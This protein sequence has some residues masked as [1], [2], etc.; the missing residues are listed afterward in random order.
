MNTVTK[1]TILDAYERLAPVVTR[2]P[3]TR[4]AGL[5]KRFDADIYLKREDLQEVR[6][7]KIRGSYNR[8]ALLSDLERARGIVCASAGNHAQGVAKSCA[9]LSIRGKVYMP[10]N[11]PRQKVDRVRAFGKDVVEVVLVGDSFDESFAAA[12]V[13]TEETGAVLVHPFDDPAVVSGQGT[14]AVEVFE[15]L[16]DVD[17]FVIP[18]GGGGLIAGMGTYAK[19]MRSKVQVIGVEPTGAASMY[20]A[21]THGTVVTL[22]AVDTFVDGVAVKTVGKN[23]FALAEKCVDHYELVPEGAVCTVMVALYQENGIVTEPAGALSVAALD[24]MREQLVGKKVVCVISGGNNDISRYAEVL[25]RS[26]V[27]RGLKHY[28]VVSFP[29]RPGALRGFLND[30][31]GPTDDITLFEYVKKNNRETG[32]ALVGIE[33]AQ[34][35]DLAALVDRMD[36]KGI[37]YEKLL[38]DSP[39]YR[40][41]V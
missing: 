19:S 25:E 17:L 28:F 37:V 34:P 13:H 22:P 38:P 20:A 29:Q 23:T 30:V 12:R 2:T 9:T 5:S 4:H 7:Y 36:T 40:F 8:M 39:L 26:L 15:E 41:V 24:Q 14:V 18:V 33:L 10:T 16:P 31:L 35:G 11:T 6:S 27:Y 21:H 1:E 32:P 3:L